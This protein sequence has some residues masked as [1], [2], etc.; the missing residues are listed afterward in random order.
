M[1]N[2][3]K[4]SFWRILFGLLIFIISILFLIS[5]TVNFDN[6]IDDY[7]ALK[8]A[9][10]SF[11]DVI[12][13]NFPELVNPIGPFGAYFGFWIFFGLGKFF[14]IS[15][16]LCSALLGFFSI[17]IGKDNNLLN[18]L[19]SFVIFAFF[20]NFILFALWEESTIHA[21]YIPWIVYNFLNSIFGHIGTLIISIIITLAC[22]CFIFELENI[23]NLFSYLYKVI[24]YILVILYKLLSFIFI[25][26]ISLFKRSKR[27]KEVIKPK[28]TKK[29]PPKPKKAL[30]KERDINITDHTTGSQDDYKEAGSGKS[31]L[32]PRIIPRPVS[33]EK[34]NKNIQEIDNIAYIKPEIDSFLSSHK[35]TRKD[36]E[37]I[38]Q[39][40]RHV[41]TIL[42]RKLLE[43]GVEAEVTNVNIGPII[44]QYEIKPAPGVK[45]NK[46]HSLADDLALAI[47]ATSIRVQA[48]IPGRGLVGIEIPNI[49]RDTIYLKDILLSNEMKS[50]HS[51]L[52]F[53]LGKDIAGNPITADLGQMPHLLIAGATGS[54]KS[55]CVNTIIACFLFRT[56]PDEVRL[57]LIDPKRIELSGYEGIPHLIQNVVTN[58]D[59]ALLALNWGVSE[60]ERRYDLLQKYKAK[61]LKAYNEKIKKL[62]LNNEEIEDVPLPFIIIVV[63]ELADLMMTVGRDVERPITRLAQMAR[64]IGIHLIL[65]T[66]RPSIKVI[67]GII[68][69]N[70]PSRI[71]FKVSTKIDSRVIIDANGAEKL[72][73]L[74]DML[75]LAPGT[76]TP[77]RIH[78]AYIPPDETHALVEYLKTQPSPE[79]DIK[80]IS[81]EDYAL[82]EFDFDDELFPEAAIAVVTAGSASVSMLQRHFKIGYA[83]AGR[84][85]DMLEKANIIGPFVGSKSREVLA[86]EEELKIYGYLKE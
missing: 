18:K 32:P 35:S 73:G 2:K 68:K 52:A 15:I 24:R 59:D 61:N 69:A 63:D 40:I 48:P 28:K 14:S 21:G 76:G 60:M 51:K 85:I 57:I 39:N 46:F 80:I 70:F 65:A 13:M 83:R 36:R 81:E 49:K 54:G 37:E 45:V 38:E 8:N 22:L 74:G 82:K 56:N 84:L 67:T 41:S 79:Q 72:L 44:T 9:D 47:K 17:F 43:F 20:F 77:N 19:I 71:A 25:F 55:V 78:G 4:S 86:T 30:P 50:M 42:E 11:T 64:A 10:L 66:Q 34:S 5:L 31:Q 27:K 1:Q 62:R 26:F 7:M 75:F 53:A 29:K 3:K 12:N 6:L 58:N 16:L 33:P 23:K